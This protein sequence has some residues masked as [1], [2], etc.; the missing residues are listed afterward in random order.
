MTE[1]PHCY[2]RVVAIQGRC[3][4]CRRHLADTK[5]ADRTKAV[6]AIREREP[7]PDICFA[8]GTPTTRRVAVRFRR[9]R[10]A[11]AQAELLGAVAAVMSLFVGVLL[12]LFRLRSGT[13]LV[14][15]L[16]Q[17]SECARDGAPEARHVDWAE[18]EV[19]F[20]VDKKFRKALKR[21][22]KPQASTSG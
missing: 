10:A 6:V 5:G 21:L 18:F 3:P 22:A 7:L 1:C 9:A 4:A 12:L 16:P 19:T 17:C 2:T 11:D 14:V 20:V 13:R 8:C 15:R